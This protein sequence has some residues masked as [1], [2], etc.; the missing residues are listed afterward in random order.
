MGKTV[1]KLDTAG[2]AELLKS[3]EIESV[4][5]NVGRKIAAEA[6]PE[7]ETRRWTERKRAAVNVADF[8]EGAFRREAATGN[9]AKAVKRV[10]K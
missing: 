6:G 5:H 4:L 3:G 8:T 1:I 7:Y 10:K 9:L 2:V